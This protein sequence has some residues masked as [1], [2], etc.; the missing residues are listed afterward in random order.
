MPQRPADRG[1]GGGGDGDGD[2]DGEADVSGRG[3]SRRLPLPALAPPLSAAVLPSLSLSL[4]PLAA[5]AGRAPHRQFRPA[6]DGDVFS[7]HGKTA[8]GRGL[9]D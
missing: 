1:S 9:F 2:W 5:P 3:G 6:P 4:A 7:A 8:S